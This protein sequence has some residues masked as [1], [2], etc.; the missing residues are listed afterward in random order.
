MIPDEH[1]INECLANQIVTQDL[2][3]R[4]VCAEMITENLNDDQGVV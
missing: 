2:N 4:K 1:N 3:T